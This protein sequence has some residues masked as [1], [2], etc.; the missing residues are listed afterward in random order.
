MK[1]VSLGDNLHEL[2]KPIF[3]ENK[4]PISRFRLLIFF[5]QHIS[6][7]PGERILFHRATTYLNLPSEKGF[8]LSEKYLVQG[9]TLFH[10]ENIPIYNFDPLKP[11]YYIV[12]LG[13]TGYT[14][15]SYFTIKHRL[16]V[17]VRTA[18]ARRF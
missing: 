12:K 11:H 5:T 9:T 10:H 15:F 3:W 7:K 17:F 2:S 14:L 4:K 8:T 18:S 6:I 13:F 16:W 1:I